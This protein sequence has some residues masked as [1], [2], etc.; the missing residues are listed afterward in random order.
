MAPLK[1]QLCNLPANEGLMALK[2]NSMIYSFVKLNRIC[3]KKETLC[4]LC[5]S[6][7]TEE[8]ALSFPNE[9]NDHVFMK[10][11]DINVLPA[12]TD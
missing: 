12:G 4:S 9:K 1:M 11:N 8:F 2:R 5:Y 10:L 6:L 3:R 7:C